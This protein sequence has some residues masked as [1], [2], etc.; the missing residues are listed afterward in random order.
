[1]VPFV[2]GIA[3][4]AAITSMPTRKLVMSATMAITLRL[5][6]LLPS[7]SPRLVW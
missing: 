4:Y 2:L 1:M 5:T 7:I 6:V 3:A